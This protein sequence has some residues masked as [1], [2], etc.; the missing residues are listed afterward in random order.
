MPEPPVPPPPDPLLTRASVTFHT[1]DDD[2][3]NDTLVEV[4]VRLSDQRT[5]VAKLSDYLGHFPDHSDAGPF[6]LLMVHP[7]RRSQLR[8]GSVNIL[9]FAN[10]TL[11]P[12]GHGDTWRFNFVVG[13]PLRRRR[14]SAR[15][16]QRRAAEIPGRRRAAVVRDRVKGSQEAQN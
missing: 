15:A 10:T 16:G 7:A 2:K 9:A 1:N 4:E 8:T 5:V 13:S 12:F 11:P 6:T 14:A 3:D